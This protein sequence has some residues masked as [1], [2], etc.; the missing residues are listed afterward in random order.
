MYRSMS[1]DHKISGSAR[2]KRAVCITNRVQ[3][4]VDECRLQIREGKPPPS[5]P[6]IKILI[7][8]AVK[9]EAI[10]RHYPVSDAEVALAAAQAKSALGGHS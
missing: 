10:I 7:R 1:R 4:V 5:I 3:E 8:E 2:Y 9:G 6:E